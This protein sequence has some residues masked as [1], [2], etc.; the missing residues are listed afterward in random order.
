ME[1]PYGPF[2]RKFFAKGAAGIS[3]CIAVSGTAIGSAEASSQVQ[4]F[5]ER[6]NTLRS[7]VSQFTAEDRAQLAKL[8]QNLAQFSDFS[9]F[10][11]FS[12]FRDIR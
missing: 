1:N 7:A 2:L 4:P 11:S 3:V 9:S 10:S 6:L 12:A 5:S 8:G